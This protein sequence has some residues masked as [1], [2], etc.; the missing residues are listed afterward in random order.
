MT[1]AHLQR[2]SKLRKPIL[3]LAAA[4]LLVLSAAA[5]ALAGPPTGDFAVFSQCQLK[6]VV[7][8]CIYA[9][10]TSGEEQ[11]GKASVP[12]VHTITLQ[13]GSY[14][15]PGGEEFVGAVDGETLSQTPQN[16]SGGLPAVVAYGSLSTKTRQTLYNELVE[17]GITGVTATI[18]LVGKPGISL[19]N[20]ALQNEVALSLPVQIKLSNPF[21]GSDCHIGSAASP[22]VF[23]LTTGT[24]APDLPN[25]PVT[26][27]PGTF[28]V[29]IASELIEF[30][31]YELRDNAFALPTAEGCGGSE[32]SIVDPAVNTALDLPSPDGHNS[33][34]L[35]GTLKVATEQAVLAST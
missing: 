26:G 8:Y 22:V 2:P 18:E 16:V 10:A 24:T 19:E 35:E 27:T 15:V 25:D 4:S 31:G 33:V 28:S 12:I 29:I 14:E 9:Q 17:D 34:D 7:E 6:S 23:N 1:M 20:F 11:L 30:S 13:G 5:P 21:L 3:V 32:S